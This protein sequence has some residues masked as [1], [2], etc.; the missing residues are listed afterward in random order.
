MVARW[1]GVLQTL[2][3][4]AFDGLLRLLP[5]EEADRRLLIVAADEED[6]GS[7][8]YGY[9][10]PDEILAELL[11]KLHQHQ[12]AAIGV[13]IFRDRPQEPLA[14]F[15]QEHQNIIGVCVGINL[16]ESVAPPPTLAKANI[17]FVDLYDDR[18]ETYNRDDTV[19]RYLL[20]RTPNP[21]AIPSHCSSQD[22]PYSFALQLAYPYLEARGISVETS[23]QD[24]QFGSVVFKRLQERSGGY[25]KLD[26]RGNQLLI[27]YRRTPQI[28]QQVTFKDVLEA[29]TNFDPSWV[30]DRVVLVGVAADSIPDRHDTPFGEIRGLYVHAHVVS[31]ILSTVEDERP[32]LWWLPQWGDTLWVLVC[33]FTGGV[34][35]CVFPTRLQQG[36]AGSITIIILSG[37]CWLGLTQ[38]V[39]LPL[40]PGILGLSLAA[41]IV[42]FFL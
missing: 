10:L 36:I 4:K 8:G 14:S 24:W 26:A 28:A 20:S 3:L 40:I 2:E 19:R 22:Y 38:G 33:S 15:L 42:V 35:I 32:L 29:T 23:G 17:G 39:W 5:R 37:V 30:K 34:V 18:G 12:P 25:Q 21:L 1:L 16:E 31:Q 9:P 27:H 41:G 6:I 11:A 13:D 7:S